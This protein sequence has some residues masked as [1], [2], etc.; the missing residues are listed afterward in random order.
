MCQPEGRQSPGAL[1]ANWREYDGSFL[2]KSRLA[3]RNAWIKVRTRS[4]C[5]GNGGEPGC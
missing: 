5:C 1:F 3:L 2:E 4:N